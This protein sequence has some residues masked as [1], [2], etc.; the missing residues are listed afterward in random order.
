MIFNFINKYQFT[1]RLMSNAKI[2]EVLPKLKLLGTIICTDLAW[3]SNTANIVRRANA[4]MIILRKLSEYGAPR[5]NFKNIYILYIQSVLEQ[6]AMVWH[7]SLTQQSTED[8]NRVLKS[9]C[10]IM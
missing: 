1:T 5:E 7:S 8:L 3:D 9:A 2:L 4:I 10:K 6:S